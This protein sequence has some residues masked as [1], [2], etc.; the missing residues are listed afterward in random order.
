MSNKINLKKNIMITMIKKIQK[1]QLDNIKTIM[2]KYQIIIKII[3]TMII[4]KDILNRK[5]ININ[6]NNR[7]NKLMKYHNNK[8][9]IIS[10]V[11]I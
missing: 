4:V 6:F 7:Y 9:I 10:M 8:I 5:K 1:N 11:T 2:K 3:I